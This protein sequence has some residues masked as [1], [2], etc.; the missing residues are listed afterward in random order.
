MH[1]VVIIS[2]EGFYISAGPQYV[3]SILIEHGYKCAVLQ[4]LDMMERNQLDLLVDKYF[5]NDKQILGI[6]LTFVRTAESKEAVKYFADKV[7]EKFPNIRIVVGGASNDLS[8]PK[9]LPTDN[10]H[11]LMGQNRE[12]EIIDL[13][14]RLTGRVKRI[15]FDFRNHSINYDELFPTPTKGVLMFLKISSGC[16]FNCAFCNFDLRKTKSTFKTKEKVIEEM[17]AFHRRFGTNEIVLICNTFNDDEDKI[18]MMYEAS[19]ELSFTPSYFVFTRLD[20]FAV[21]KPFVHEFY[22]KYVKYSFF[23]VESFNSQTLKVINKSPNVE[24]LKASLLDFRNKARSDVYM[25]GSFIVGLPHETLDDH[26]KTVAW[27]NETQVFDYIN[28]PSLQMNPVEANINEYSDMD[29]NPEKYGYRFIKDS[30]ILDQRIRQML[31]SFWAR[32][33]GY[34]IE[35]AHRD[36]LVVNALFRNKLPYQMHMLFAARGVEPMNE[37]INYSRHSY[38]MDVLGIGDVFN[39]DRFAKEYIGKANI[40][41]DKFIDEY[42]ETLIT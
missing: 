37:K 31:P 10:I 12:N 23:G 34:T 27:I 1:D 39:N 2:A 3:T 41:I 13:F 40:E 4:A 19:E 24:R 17:E 8:A 7:R 42:Y 5:T 21:Q 20:L 26:L 22:R 28:Y 30:E 14:N 18:K 36:S 29:Q 16:K 9:I 35:N 32:D 25:I 15:P 33:D 38:G 11:Y 6:S